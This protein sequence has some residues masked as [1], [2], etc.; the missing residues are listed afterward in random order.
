VLSSAQYLAPGQRSR[1]V[2][3][4]GAPV[5]NYYASTDTGPIAWECLLGSGRFHVLVPDVWVE[6][7]AGELVVTRLRP[8]VLPLLR[9]RTGDHGEVA[10]DACACGYHG[11]SITCFA[12]RRECTFLA[13]DGREADAW[14]LAWLFKHYPLDSF[15]LTQR[16][17]E[18]FELELRPGGGPVD[19]ADLVSRLQAALAR[20]GWAQARVVPVPALAIAAAGEKPEPFRRVW[21]ARPASAIA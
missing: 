5:V 2:E 6:S 4:L 11:W 19:V 15:R 9:Y 21:S 13:P 20:L 12:G 16:G 3:A 17:A 18:E 14:K 7:V 8:S 10:R 1:A